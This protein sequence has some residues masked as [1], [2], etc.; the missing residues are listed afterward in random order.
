MLKSEA[1]S[2][3]LALPRLRSPPFLG[4]RVR[5]PWGNNS[6]F[7]FW[8]L[9]CP[10]LLQHS[11]LISLPR[12]VR[13]PVNCTPTCRVSWDSSEEEAVHPS[14]SPPPGRTLSNV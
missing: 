6:L 10:G 3:A 8:Y 13:R 12:T 11:P 7:F 1:S 9:F 4:A 5:P 14:V 2:Q